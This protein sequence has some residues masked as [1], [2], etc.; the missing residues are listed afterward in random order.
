MEDPASAGESPDIPTQGNIQTEIAE[1]RLTVLPA[2]QELGS[3]IPAEGISV[4]RFPF[5][6]GRLPL[7]KEPEPS[8]AIDLT[9]ADSKPFRLSRQH[10]A[11]SRHQDKPVVM[12]LGSTLG[13]E[14]NGEPL[15]YH[16]GKDFEFLKVGETRIV[17]GGLDS[18]FTFTVLMELA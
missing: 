13:T 3:Q 1:S 16:F 15:G 12:D 17:A 10:F 11:L 18:P 5:S 6:V 4:T 14:V 2:S 8:V 9:L 7:P